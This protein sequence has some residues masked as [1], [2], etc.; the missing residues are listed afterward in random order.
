MKQLNINVLDQVSG[1]G[2]LRQPVDNPQSEAGKTINDVA[3]VINDLGGWI[4]RTVYDWLN[5]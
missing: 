1:A 4:G 2:D 5:P 3:Q